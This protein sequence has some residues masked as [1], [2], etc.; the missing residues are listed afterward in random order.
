ME[1][2]RDRE[3]L[4]TLAELGLEVAVALKAQ[5]VTQAA[6][7]DAEGAD[8]LSLAFTH[9]S[10]SIR[11]TLVFKAKLAE[12]KAKAT[13]KR[14][15]KECQAAIETSRL[16]FKKSQVA[17]DVAEM[18]ESQGGSENL[19]TDLHERLNDP[20]IEDELLTIRVGD[21]IFGL[22]DDLGIL[23]DRTVWQ[24]KG[25]FLNEDRPR[26]E[27]PPALSRGGGGMPTHEWIR[28]RY[29]TPPDG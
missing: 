8:R 18:V 21:V 19:L 7:G 2:A 14:K 11:Q 23:I 27:P 5:I 4:E 20:D 17:R 3:I 25:W 15:A 13:E 28:Q 9:V 12:M 6:A 26:P 1:T 24:D 22:C 16:R 29:H 10:R